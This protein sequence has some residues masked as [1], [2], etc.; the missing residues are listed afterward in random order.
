MSEVEKV[1]PRSNGEKQSLSGDLG[2]K[3]GDN[4]GE[5]ETPGNPF[6]GEKYHVHRIGHA[7]IP[8]EVKLCQLSRYII[9]ITIFTYYL[10]IL[11]LV[12]LVLVLP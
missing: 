9:S 12:V 6:I 4:P 11:L 10:I 1:R 3:A 7:W 8:A 2:Q 5:T